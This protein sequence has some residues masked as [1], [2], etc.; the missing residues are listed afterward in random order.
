MSN[1]WPKVRLGEV[2]TRSEETIALQPDKE[3]RE[4]TVRLWG[5][6]VVLRGIVSGAGVAAQR[7]YVARSGQFILSRIDARNG[8]LGVVPPELDGAVVTNDFPLFIVNGNKLLVEYLGWLCRTESFVDEC[9]RASEGTT[10]R[11][12]LQ[13]VKFL[14]RE[15]LLPPLAEQRRIVARIKELVEQIHEVRDLRKQEEQEIRQMLNG[16]FQRIISGASHYPMIDIAP[17]IRR[18]VRID[19]QVSY[20]ELGVRSF[21]KGTFHKPA[22][23]GIEIGSKRVFRIEPGD[24]IFSNVFAWEGAIAVAK[25][26]DAGRVGSHRFITRVPKPDVA[27]SRF[28]NFYFLTSEGIELI[29]A[30]SPGGAGRNR[31]LGLTALDAIQVPVPSIEQQM[32]FDELQVEVDGLKRLQAETSIEL[33]ALLLSI[34]SRAFKGEL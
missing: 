12:R 24:L 7:R 19:H 4:I 5:K 3:Y 10:N 14:A 16:A 23:T 34:L 17:Q 26:E 6:G 9:L 33:D 11:V 15:I 29:R 31:T 22:L 32:W 21:G 1:Q 2:L 13:G 20:P 30:A 25:A 8:A 28:L 27:T 18:P